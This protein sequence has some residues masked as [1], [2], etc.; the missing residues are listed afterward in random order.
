MLIS[1]VI[2]DETFKNAINLQGIERSLLKETLNGLVKPVLEEVRTKL[3]DF[4]SLTDF[5]KE[6]F[7]AQFQYLETT[8]LTNLVGGYEEQF[9]G[10]LVDLSETQALQA[11]NE[12]NKAVRIPLL[13]VTSPPVFFKTLVDQTLIEGLPLFTQPNVDGSL[14]W[15]TKL[16]TD[17]Q[18]KVGQEIR[19]GL[20]AGDTPQQLRQ[21]VIGKRDKKGNYQGGVLSATRREAE[22]IT[23]TAVHAVTNET[24]KRIYETNQDVIE[25]VQSLAT[26]D[27]RTT[28]LCRS[29]DGLKWSL[30][31]YKPIGHTKGYLPPPRHFRCRSVLVPVPVGIDEIDRKAKEMGLEITPEVRSANEGPVVSSSQMDTGRDMELWFSKQSKESQNEMLGKGRADLW[32]KGDVSLYQMVNEQGRTLTLTELSEQ[33]KNNSLQNPP[34]STKK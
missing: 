21:R 15:W 30:P 25:A 2:K 10:Y 29:F 7:V 1:E 28:I 13:S 6:R 17:T 24:R 22:A 33:V 32:R 31:D 27:G 34:V 3:K 12:I 23:R 18:R 14:S 20:I 9:K 8:Y 19:K 5:Q 4:D 26:L 11:V 16:G